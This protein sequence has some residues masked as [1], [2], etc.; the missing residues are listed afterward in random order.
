M[1][2]WIW[3][4]FS[5]GADFIGPLYLQHQGHS[6]TVIGVEKTTVNTLR[7]LILDPSFA[8]KRIEAIRTVDS[9]SSIAFLRRPIGHMKK[10]QFQ[11]VAVDGL[12]TD[13]TEYERSKLLHGCHQRVPA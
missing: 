3:D 10:P 9:D 7:L 12:M 2:K 13:D 1:F 6:R 8:R 5:S 4:Y 11:I